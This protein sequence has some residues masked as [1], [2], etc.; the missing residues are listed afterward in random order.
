MSTPAV[1]R[2]LDANANRAREALRVLEDLARFGL[3]DES[4]AGRLKTLRHE[5]TAALEML[6][7]GWLAANRDPAGDVGRQL[8]TEGERSRRDLVEVASAADGRLGEALRAIEECGKTI[9]PALAAR[10]EAL[11]YRGY[12]LALAVYRGLATGRAWQWLVGVLITESLCRRPW[13]ETVQAALAGGA[14]CLQLREK[15]L[16][17]RE[18]VSRTRWLVQIARPRGVSVIVNDRADVAVAGGADGVHLGQADLDATDVRRLWGRALLVGISTHDP[19]EAA[20]AVASGVD[21]C[22]VGPMFPTAVKPGRQ[23]AGPAYLQRFIQDHPAVPHLAIG[24]IDP[25]SLPTLV[26]VGVR[27]I[28]ATTA[29]CGAEDPGAVVAELRRMMEKRDGRS[30]TEGP[31]D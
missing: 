23:P 1:A 11:R 26:A 4:S 30:G 10:V 31:R 27:G 9:H 5:L 28:A 3:D 12:E 18:L 8:S 13:R 6:P 7:A 2:I 29:V 20:R 15:D 22:G 14:D 24:G 19:D 25:K 17:G 16:G 21:Y